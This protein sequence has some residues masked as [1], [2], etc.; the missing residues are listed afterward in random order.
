[1][2]VSSYVL[3][4]RPVFPL[5]TVV[6]W[7]HGQSQYMFPLLATEWSVSTL[8]ALGS[9]LCSLHSSTHVR[10]CSVGLCRLYASTAHLG[11]V[12]LGPTAQSQLGP[13]RFGRARKWL[14]PIIHLGQTIHMHT[15]SQLVFDIYI[16]RFMNTLKL[17]ISVKPFTCTHSQLFIFLFCSFLKLF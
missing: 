2:V 8:W 14:W 12:Q 6:R 10:H 15:H 1:M 4:V 7:T 9:C 5:H 3:P 17:F 16:F 13:A 11:I